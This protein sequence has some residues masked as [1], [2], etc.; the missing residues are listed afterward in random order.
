MSATEILDQL[1]KLS[2]QERR[3]ISNRLLELD[4]D[5]GILEES[6]QQADEAFQLLDA[7]ENKQALSKPC[8]SPAV[9]VRPGNAVGNEKT[10]IVLGSARGGTT[11]IAEILHELGIPIG[12]TDIEIETGKSGPDR[13]F[14][15][16][17]KEFSKWLHY[18]PDSQRGLGESVYWSGKT[19]MGPADFETDLRR[20]VE[21]IDERNRMSPVWG[22][23]LPSVIAWLQHPTLPDDSFENRFRNP[24]F[25]SIWRDPVAVWTSEAIRHNMPW[26]DSAF[27]TQSSGR[28][29]FSHVTERQKW[30]EDFL[31]RSQSPHLA[32]SYERTIRGRA[33]ALVDSIVTFLNLSP[34]STKRWNAITSVKA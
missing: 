20:V 33:E 13:D 16:E 4:E 24:H 29:P 8:S 17:D 26:P 28:R 23:K 11:M 14:N 6:R 32:V 9:I 2:P 27:L 12:V 18:N 5:A 22:F 1:P 30:V 19:E 15:Y 31:H 21:L 10:V 25:I 7:E 3:A 34:T